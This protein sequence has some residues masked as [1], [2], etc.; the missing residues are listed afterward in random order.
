MRNKERVLEYYAKTPDGM[1]V[2]AEIVDDGI[3]L[4]WQ[5]RSKVVDGSFVLYDVNGNIESLRPIGKANYPSLMRSAGIVKIDNDFVEF[6]GIEFFNDMIM[7]VMRHMVNMVVAGYGD[8]L[9]DIVDWYSDISSLK[10]L[11]GTKFRFDSENEPFLDMIGLIG[12][13][14]VDDCGEYIV[15]VKVAN[16]VFKIPLDSDNILISFILSTTPI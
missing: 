9:E 13:V 3:E 16:N 5:V 10:F 15:N 12:F 4:L 6:C 14:D 1:W 2:K 8:N 7:S 11:I